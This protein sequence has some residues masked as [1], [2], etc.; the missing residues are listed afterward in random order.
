M[1]FET[2]NQ[3]EECGADIEI[4]QENLYD[5]FIETSL[6]ESV[7][8][9]MRRGFAESPVQGDHTG[10]MFRQLEEKLCQV[11]SI[12]IDGCINGAFCTFIENEKDGKA[13]VVWALGGDAMHVWLVQFLHYLQRQAM[14]EGCNSVKFGGRVGWEKVLKRHGF[15]TESV[16]MRQKLCH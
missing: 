12:K 9:Y 4:A 10:A 13:Y 2:V 15:S 5:P 8:D 6:V 14:F 3:C 16:I 1:G 11:H 7:F